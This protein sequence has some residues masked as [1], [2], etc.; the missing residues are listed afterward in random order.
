MHHAAEGEAE[1][2][3]RTK[4]ALTQLHRGLLA[5]VARAQLLERGARVDEADVLSSPTAGPLNPAWQSWAPPVARTLDLTA[6]DLRADAAPRAERR[7]RGEVLYLQ[8]VGSLALAP[9][10]ITHGHITWNGQALATTPP[11][12]DD[13]G[14]GGPH[15]CGAGGPTRCPTCFLEEG[16]HLADLAY[17]SASELGGSARAVVYGDRYGDSLDSLKIWYDPDDLEHQVLE[18]AVPQEKCLGVALRYLMEAMVRLRV[19]YSI[20]PA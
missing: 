6:L 12:H 10:A 11:E 15:G 16:W 9:R 3:L 4:R 2:L 20:Q 17:R 13:H 8:A 7:R 19:L 5:S 1:A 14:G 18:H